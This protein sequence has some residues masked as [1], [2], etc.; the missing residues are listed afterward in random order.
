MGLGKTVQ[1]IA[2]MVCNPPP[3]RAAQKA[4]LIVCSPAI[5]NNWDHEIAKHKNRNVLPTVIR[6]YGAT[7]LSD[8]GASGAHSF[9][10]LE[11]ADIV[12]TTYS[13]LSKSYPK[14]NVPATIADP[15][16]QKHEWQKE[17]ELSRGLLHRVHWYRVI[18]DGKLLCA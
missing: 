13:E 14:F 7:R 18:I 12:L 8:N 15:N 2:L 9:S 6:H 17:W 3:P 4:T 11:N 1:T 10:M 16:E 5:I